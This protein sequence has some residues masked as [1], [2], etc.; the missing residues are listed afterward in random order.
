MYT[1]FYS[2]VSGPLR[3][4]PPILYALV[5][6]PKKEARTMRPRTLSDVTTYGERLLL[7][8]AMIPIATLSLAALL[9]PERFAH[10]IGAAGTNPYVYRLVGAAALGYAGSLAWA[11]RSG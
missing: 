7:L 6:H 10:F 11:L 8:I 9:I 5:S 1:V 3:R 2:Q 4:E